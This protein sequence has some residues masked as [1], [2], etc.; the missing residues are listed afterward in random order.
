M[1]IPADVMAVIT[2]TAKQAAEKVVAKQNA[3]L[4][5]RRDRRLHN[6]QLL[7]KN[8]RMFK[9]HCT[10]AVY[11]DD[12][13]DHDGSEEEEAIELLDMMM[14]QNRA[15]VVES[16][17]MSCRRT[18]I[19]I[20]HIDNVLDVY[21]VYCNKKADTTEGRAA[22]RGCQALRRFYTSDDEPTLEQIAD[23]LGV[24][25]RQ[26]YR[27]MSAAVAQV[28]IFLFGVDALDTEQ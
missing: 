22:R 18:K 2:E 20:K 14:N 3:Q 25:S 16:I 23:E 9:L 17:R 7:L 19:I 24:S 12:K 13:G 8:Y 11:T 21:E 6:T 15:A 27:D 5:E 4:K 28:S 26:V 10:G 1:D